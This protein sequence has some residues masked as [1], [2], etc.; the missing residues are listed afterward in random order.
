MHTVGPQYGDI[1]LFGDS[2]N[3]EGAVEFY[4]RSFGWTGICPDSSWGT[5]DATVACRQLGYETGRAVTYGRYHYTYMYCT[6]YTHVW[7][8]P[9]YDCACMGLT[10]ANPQPENDAEICCKLK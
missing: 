5:S 9:K 4:H 1:R 2:D 10:L 7:V 6:I 8:T 3:G